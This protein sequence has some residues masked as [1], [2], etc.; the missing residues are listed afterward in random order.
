M[1]SKAPS[2]SSRV[3]LMNFLWSS[4]VLSHCPYASSSSLSHFQD[5]KKNLFKKKNPCF[6][7]CQNYNSVLET[8]TWKWWARLK[9][10]EK[11]NAQYCLWQYFLSFYDINQTISWGPK[12]MKLKEWYSQIFST[13]TS[14]SPAEC[15][16]LR[17]Q[18][19]Q[20]AGLESWPHLSTAVW[21]EASYWV[22]WT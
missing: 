16:T 10:S 8:M 7:Y 3:C 1:T 12:I 22:S 20:T 4:S 5:W 14:I 21:G 9:T 15:L 19:N 18:W 13:W 17:R 2:N 11:I 6:D